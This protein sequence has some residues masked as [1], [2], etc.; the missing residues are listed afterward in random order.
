MEWDNIYPVCAGNGLRP[1]NWLDS[2]KTFGKKIF[3]S[4]MH[5]FVIREEVRSEL[6]A[7]T[8][9]HMTK[10]SRAVPLCVNIDIAFGKVILFG[11]EF[12]DRYQ[13]GLNSEKADTA[14]F[15]M[16]NGNLTVCRHRAV[17]SET[18]HRRCYHSQVLQKRLGRLSSTKA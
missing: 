11:Q 17:S 7:K 9:E 8:K 12:R 16:S 5:H 15:R 18:A 10:V 14:P 2:E 3:H 4:N 13:R 1:R 6:I